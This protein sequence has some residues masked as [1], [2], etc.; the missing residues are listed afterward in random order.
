M[1][2][3]DGEYNDNGVH[4]DLVAQTQARTAIYSNLRFRRYM[5]P[6]AT[7]QDLSQSCHPPSSRL[8]FSI[9]NVI[10]SPRRHANTWVT[11]FTL[12]SH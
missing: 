4:V 12:A 9:V 8:P 6:F 7:G 2:T 5:L 10:Y 3:V 1:V 11:V